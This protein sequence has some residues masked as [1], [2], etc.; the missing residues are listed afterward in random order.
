MP[1][2]NNACPPYHERSH[3]SNQGLAP[4][5]R[6]HL[7]HPLCSA[8]RILPVTQFY[9]MWCRI[10]IHNRYIHPYSRWFILVKLHADHGSGQW[11]CPCGEWRQHSFSGAP[12][13]AANDEAS[14]ELK[15]QMSQKSPQRALCEILCVFYV[16]YDLP[17]GWFFK[18]GLSESLKSSQFPTCG[19]KVWKSCGHDPFGDLLS[20]LSFWLVRVR[21]LNTELLD[22]GTD[23]ETSHLFSIVWYC[24]CM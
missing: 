2:W 1:H 23:I 11:T 9:N 12:S 5:S 22:P 4:Y 8:G 6:G 21:L 13:G 15:L 10:W 7:F 16:F 17:G 19:R 3:M 24:F 14:P 18:V 20:T